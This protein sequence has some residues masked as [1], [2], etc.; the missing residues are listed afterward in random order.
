MAGFSRSSD[1]DKKHHKKNVSDNCT[2]ITVAR[3]GNS[4][5]ANGPVVFL[6][7]EKSENCLL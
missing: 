5:G 7:K 2:S 3:V 4:A 1:K 6:L